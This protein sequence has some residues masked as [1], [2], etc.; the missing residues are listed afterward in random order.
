[1]HEL[2]ICQ[3]LIAQL[4]ALPE[5][6]RVSALR[7]SIGPL[8]GVEPALLSRAFPLA[9]AG[10]RAAGARLEME[11]P[12]VRIRCRSC[13]ATGEVP[14]NRLLCPAC[15]DWHCSVTGGD[16]MTLLS[17]EL[18]EAAPQMKETDNV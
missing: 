3:A 6:G 8:S 4:E 10:S 15:G 1:M 14:P 18:T 13:G 16:E 5:A 2:S 12:P 9:A 7:L 17:V 11:T